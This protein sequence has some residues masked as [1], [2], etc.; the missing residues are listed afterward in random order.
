MVPNEPQARFTVRVPMVAAEEIDS[1][2]DAARI[3]RS[4]FQSMALVI[5]A[6][7]LARQLV[8]E[9]LMTPADIKKFAE[10]FASSPEL[11]ALI[12]KE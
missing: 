2:A 5:G 12:E 9:L 10:V 4:N 6:R 1:W 7:Q 8:P 11:K 3:K